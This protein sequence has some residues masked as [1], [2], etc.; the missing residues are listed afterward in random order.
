MIFKVL[1]KTFLLFLNALYF[2]CKL[3]PGYRHILLVVQYDDAVISI[4]FLQLCRPHDDSALLHIR[5]LGFLPNKQYIL[6][7]YDM[8]NKTKIFQYRKK[9]EFNKLMSTL[10]YILIFPVN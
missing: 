9:I 3:L 5:Y 6:A 2:S 8:I 10:S 7:G 4:S 1:N